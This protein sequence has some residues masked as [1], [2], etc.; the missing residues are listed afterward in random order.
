M[1]EYIGTIILEH[2]RYKLDVHIL[3]VYLL[4]EINT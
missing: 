1:E 2:L 4:A 3:N